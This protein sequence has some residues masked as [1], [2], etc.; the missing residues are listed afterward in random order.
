MHLKLTSTTDLLFSV[1]YSELS[2]YKLETD[3]IDQMIGPFPVSIDR[4]FSDRIESNSAAFEAQYLC[5]NALLSCVYGAGRFDENRLDTNRFYEVVTTPLFPAPMITDTPVSEQVG[6]DFINVYAY[7]HLKMSDDVTLTIGLAYDKFENPKFEVDELNPKLG[8]AWSIG[9]NAVLRA[10]YFEG[11]TRPYN[12]ELTIEPTQVAG[13]NQQFDDIAG[14]ETRRAGVALDIRLTEDLTAGAMVSQ[15][16]LRSPVST[17]GGP[18]SLD[19]RKEKYHHMYLN[20]LPAKRLAMSL[21]YEYEQEES[22]L[23]PPEQITT[24]RIPVQLK[25]FSAG[26]SVY[27]LKSTYVRQEIIDTGV[28]SE[29]DFV[30]TDVLYGYRLPS[31]KG[32]FQIGIHN[33]FDE[34]FNY[35]IR[36]TGIIRGAINQ[37]FLPER[38]VFVKFTYLY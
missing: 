33:V 25:Y 35:Y 19:D 3:H 23:V 36:S 20:W 9:N 21:D 4:E 15:R 18:V 1:V 34:E 14:S 27:S 8:L 32:Q 11:I 10:A 38:Y 5:R 2:H 12:A 37:P 17:I 16:K 30:L 29:D 28:S 13:F 6:A 31:R 22:Q 24:H 26:R 7:N